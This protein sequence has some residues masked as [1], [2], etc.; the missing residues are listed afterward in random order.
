M[1]DQKTF[2]NALARM[3][4]MERDYDLQMHGVLALLE[5]GRIEAGKEAI[6]KYLARRAQQHHVN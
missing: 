1:H 3:V 5:L 6:R 4:A 2:E